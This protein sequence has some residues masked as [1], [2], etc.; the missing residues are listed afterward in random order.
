MLLTQR[1]RFLVTS[2]PLGYRR[3][4]QPLR[5]VAHPVTAVLPFMGRTLLKTIR[6]ILLLV[7]TGV[8][9]RQAVAQPTARRGVLDL[10]KVDWAQQDLELRGEWKWY[11]HQ[12][13]SPNAPPATFEYVA[14]PQLWTSGSW[15]KQS[16]PSQ[17]YATYTLTVLLPPQ[18]P[19]LALE[20]PIQYSS[21]RLFVNGK[22]L[23]HDGNPATTPAE[24]RAHWSVQQVRLP[25]SADTLQL[26]LQIANFEHA[27][28]GSS[29]AIRLG[30]AT[31]L[32][33]GLA[34]NRALDLFLTG[35]LFMS[36]LFFLG[37]F[38][39]SRTQRAN[40]YF[41]LFCLAY[42][43]QVVGTEHY[44]LHTLFPDLPWWLTLRLD[45]VSLYLAVAVFVR[46]T[47]SLYPKDVYP[48]VNT[49]LIWVCLAFAG[50]TLFLPS[51]LFTRLMNSFLM[52]MVSSIGYAFYV[53]WIAA[54][55]K[56]PGAAY[57]LLS[58]GLLLGV[59]VLMIAHYFGLA[60]PMNAWLFIGYLGFFFL[61]SLVLSFRFAFALNEARQTEKQFLAN[62]SHEI[63]TPLNAILGFSNLLEATSLK[64]EQQEFVRYIRTAGKNLLM[65][66][67]DILDIAKIEAGNLQLETIPF[68]VPLLV[69][70]IRT[71][72][73]PAAT[74]KRL[75]L[76][77]DIDPAL[78]PVLLGDPTRLTQILLNLLSN[79]IKFTQQ[80]SVRVQVRKKEATANSVRVRF[81]V[82]DSG[83]G[84]AADVLPHIFERYRQA[85][86]STTRYYGG[87]GLGLSIVKSL[88]Q[89]QGGR[90]KVTSTPGQGSC[91]TVDIT[92]A[93]S[94]NP[95]D[96]PISETAPTTWE[97]AERRL[98][99]LVV[100]DNPINQKLAV[101]VLNRLGHTPQ[102]VAN[103]QL[104]LDRLREGGIDVVLM[105]IQM[106]VM[107]GYTA[108]YHIR[109]TLHSQVPIIA[110]TAH[111]LASERE[112]CLQAGM[113]DFLSKP[114]QPDDLQQLIRKYMPHSRSENRLAEPAPSP[115][116]PTPGFSMDP[117]LEVV[118]G[119]MAIAIELLELFLSQ[120]A[121]QIGQIRQALLDEDRATISR[122]LHTQKAAIQLLGLTQASQ[123]IRTL[124]ALLATEATLTEAAPLIEQLLLTLEADLPAIDSFV[125]TAL[126]QAAID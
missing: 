1:N 59:F 84:M 37:L 4:K 118:G 16:L 90:V 66:V 117:L 76:I 97:P 65:T 22:D 43:Y 68:S 14:F 109:N 73:L 77:A 99:I 30:E 104:A 61:Q 53:Y 44:V 9:A 64:E 42:S 15:Q 74:D 75:T 60:T 115:A 83:I 36:G 101:G 34:M 46:Y 119:E 35:C 95:A 103:G 13:R 82:E 45:Y 71:M 114:F 87:T 102:V 18:S 113:N 2:R 27:K 96:Q 107:D 125:Q 19:P 58:T 106:P 50:T 89:L 120:T 116:E 41:G 81:T 88:I 72:L 26:L 6:V 78:P 55:R 111:A 23:A 67:N 7:C 62:M 105:D 80:G 39:F 29:R 25:A 31:R 33:A 17:G 63:R 8:F 32:E 3:P 12:L 47:E 86:N 92:Y 100:E 70:S 108:T 48:R 85:D 124:E 24:T 69:D 20:V 112:K 54:R 56:R 38:R 10:R 28:G 94:Q 40:L 5:Q 11:W 93:I 51:V 122:V 57:S 52:L 121:E 79:A 126:G 21:Y 123:Q 91:F 98:T 49:V 110:M